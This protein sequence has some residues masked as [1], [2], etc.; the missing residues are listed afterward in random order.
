M[1]GIS[2]NRTTDEL[3]VSVV[4]CNFN[5]GETLLKT[6]E[7]ASLS[8]HPLLEILVVDDGSTDNSLELVSAQYPAVKLV[9]LGRNTQRLNIVRNT[10]I[11]A[12]SSDLVV[13]IDN[14]IS[15]APG[16]IPV[17]LR[18]LLSDDNNATASARILFENEEG[19]TRVYW[20]GGELHYLGLSVCQNRN[21]PI[22]TPARPSER[23]VGCGNL[24][25]DRKKLKQIGYFDEDYFLGWGDDGEIY[26]RF[27]S[28]GFE[29]LHVSEVSVMHI[30]KYRTSER[31]AAQLRNRWMFVCK[32]HQWQT[33]LLMAP[34]AIVFEF[35]QF[36]FCVAKGNIGIYLGA[37]MTSVK[38]F[39]AWIGARS[40]LNQDRRRGDADILISGPIYISPAAQMGSGFVSKALGL[41]QAFFNGYWRITRPLLGGKHQPSSHAGKPVV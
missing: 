2:D 7:A 4:I 21:A 9:P 19:N 17:L 28:A 16:V 33:I 29:C 41:V 40:S 23:N 6:I 27:L 8:E 13:L 32:N 18:E 1:T 25:L 31:L 22:E 15:L 24:L 3:L 14:D 20:D 37:L 26:Y 35:A 39:P 10:G 34:P 5:G 12:A 36:A 30:S 11:K 38:E